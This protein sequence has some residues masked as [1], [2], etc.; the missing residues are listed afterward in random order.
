MRVSLKDIA[1]YTGLSKSA[2]S[3][4]LNKHQLAER[5]SPATKTKIDAAVK[6]F[7][8]VP[9]Y[10][11]K[12][13]SSGKTRT[14]GFVVA[15]LAVPSN[16]LMAATL[17]DE[18]SKHDV[19]LLISATKYSPEKEIKCLEDLRSRHADGIIYSLATDAEVC[20]RLA[21]AH[22]PMV[23]IFDRDDRFHSIEN[24]FTDAMRK[25]VD[26]FRRDGA[27]AITMI[28]YS[29]VIQND[30]QE[31]CS[32]FIKA[33]EESGCT[34][35]IE[36]VSPLNAASIDVCLERISRNPPDFLIVQG[37]L[38][39]T[40]L[41]HRLRRYQNKLPSVINIIDNWEPPPL[42]DEMLVGVIMCYPDKVI[43]AAVDT[44]LRLI[45]RPEDDSLPLLVREPAKFLLSWT[46]DS[47]EK[48]V[49][50]IKRLM[51]YNAANWTMA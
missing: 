35:D 1:E 25:C 34:P 43:K 17:L 18:T 31:M 20:N 21:E 7:G 5:L 8:Y 37:P 19:Q 44:L 23:R 30:G 12:A 42:R 16:S 6:K 27:K 15:E 26:Y 40:V 50:E 4:H 51:G 13:L 47:S 32:S 29:A 24:D 49:D 45:N 3:M 33:C 28:A 41:A 14:I 48:N 10:T 36:A 2:V 46:G 22:Y 9:S 38:S 39:M 11:A